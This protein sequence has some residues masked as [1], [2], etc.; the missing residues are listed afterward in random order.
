MGGGSGRILIALN[1]MPEVKGIAV[2]ALGEFSS[3]VNVRIDGFAYED[4][5]KNPDQF[6]QSNYRAAYGRFTSG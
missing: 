2:G 5:L 6:G 1:V 4:A 3:S